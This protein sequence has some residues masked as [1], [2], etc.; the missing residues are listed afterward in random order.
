MSATLTPSI[1]GM[2]GTRCVARVEKALTARPGVQRAEVNLATE[3]AAGALAMPSGFV[4]SNA[5]R[6]R[7]VKPARATG[8]EGKV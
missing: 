2:S 7:W 4:L 1:D 5:L 3:T 6:P 8:S